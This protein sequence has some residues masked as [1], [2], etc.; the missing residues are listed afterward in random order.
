LGLI[1]AAREKG[2]K[3]PRDLKVAG[4]EDIAIAHSGDVLLT[5]YRIFFEEM[6]GQSAAPAGIDPTQKAD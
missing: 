1:G 4:M 6:G 2:L 3:V 5:T